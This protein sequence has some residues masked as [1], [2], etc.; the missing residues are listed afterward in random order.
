MNENNILGQVVSIYIQK[1]KGGIRRP[2]PKA[3]LEE[4]KGLLGDFYS[5]G[6]SRQISILTA[7]SKSEILSLRNKG[8][9]V[10]RFHENITIKN[11]DI[12]SL[13]IGSR[14]Q[15]GGT[16]QEVTQIGKKCFQECK[17]VQNNEICPLV[18]QVVFTKTLIGGTINIEDTVILL[19]P[20]KPI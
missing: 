20:L 11:L 6:G 7:E 9:C 12:S 18:T 14:I 2:V 15:I 8:L 16:V 1:Q 3:I 4:D 19:S 17:I 13:T 10:K 5:K